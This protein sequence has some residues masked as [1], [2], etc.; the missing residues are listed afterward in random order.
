MLGGKP[1]AGPQLAGLAPCVDGT[2]TL[3]VKRGGHAG[4]LSRSIWGLDRFRVAALAKLLLATPLGAADR[5]AVLA[6]LRAKCAVLATG[7]VRRGRHE[8]AAR[9]HVLAGAMAAG[10]ATRPGGCVAAGSVCSVAAPLV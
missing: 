5:D 8:E 10:A 6:T 3:V 4:Q 2:P 9:Y 1:I 7:A